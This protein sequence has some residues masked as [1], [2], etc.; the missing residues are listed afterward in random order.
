MRYWASS[1]SDLSAPSRADDRGEKPWKTRRMT[2]LFQRMS[3]LAAI[4]AGLTYIIGFWVFFTVLGPAQYGSSNVPAADHVRFLVDNQAM[5]IGWNQIIYILNAVLLV[6]VVIGLHHRIKAGQDALAQ[7]ASAFGLIWAGLILATGML[8][9]VGI[10][11]VVRL[12]EQDVDAAVVLWRAMVMVGSGLG[13]GNE[14]TGGLWIFLLSL[15]SYRSGSCP[16]ALIIMGLVIG[17]AGILSTIPALSFATMIFG[18]GFILWFF[19]IGL[20]LLLRPHIAQD[21]R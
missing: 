19:A 17:G 5:M 3:G 15:V 7:T 8:Q 6:V 14:I 20:L 11:Q 9:T 1:V 16:L 10:S 2:Q 18:L 13:G 4:A 21:G 12:A